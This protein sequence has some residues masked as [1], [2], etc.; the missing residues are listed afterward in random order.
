M[1]IYILLWFLNGQPV[2]TQEPNSI[3]LNWLYAIIIVKLISL[4]FSIA[5][6]INK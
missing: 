2:I 3:W 6:A 5:K 4:G 1:S